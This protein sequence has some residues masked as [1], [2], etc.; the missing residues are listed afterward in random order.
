MCTSASVGSSSSARPSCCA[1]TS[2]RVIIKKIA[3]ADAD[4]CADTCA[5]ST[6]NAVRAYDGA[7]LATR[8]RVY[9]R[10]GT[11]SELGGAQ[12]L[13]LMLRWQERPIE[14]RGRPGS[15]VTCRSKGVAAFIA[16]VAASRTA[17]LSTTFPRPALALWPLC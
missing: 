15:K 17:H 6:A 16:K 8:W 11:A 3:D 12:R 13:P 2:F 1:A 14:R 10:R 7:G 5:G 9:T 4:T